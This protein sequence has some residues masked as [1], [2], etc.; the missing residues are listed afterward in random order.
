MELKDPDSKSN[1]DSNPNKTFRKSIKIL[2]VLQLW[3][4][5][6]AMMV[7]KLSCNQKELQEK[8]RE[9]IIPSHL[10]TF[11]GSLNLM[12]ELQMDQ[13][14]VRLMSKRIPSPL[15]GMEE[16][17]WWCGAVFL[18]QDLAT[19]IMYLASWTSRNTR[20]FWLRWKKLVRTYWERLLKV[21]K[22]TGSSTK[23][24]IWGWIILHM[25]IKTVPFFI[26]PSKW[27]NFCFQNHSNIHQLI[28]KSLFYSDFLLLLMFMTSL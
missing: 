13:Q 15:L 28:F 19:L 23:Y 1:P 4:V 27:T 6:K 12:E 3:C 10:K 25:C 8:L 5:Y 14:N 20:P 7:F 24:W 16:G 22:A 9:E 11:W 2:P 17:H 21:L 18:W 26:W